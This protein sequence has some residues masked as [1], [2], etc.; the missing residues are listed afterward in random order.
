MP[1]WFYR[2]MHPEA[3]LTPEEKAKLIE[4]FRKSLDVAVK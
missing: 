4:G 2:P 1:P 3:R